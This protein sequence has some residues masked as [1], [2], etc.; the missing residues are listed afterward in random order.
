MLG[1][2]ESLN[3]LLDHFNSHYPNCS[4]AYEPL[5]IKH[6]TRYLL[7]WSFTHQIPK[8]TS[9]H[10][11]RFTAKTKRQQ[12]IPVNENDFDFESYIENLQLKYG[13]SENMSSS[14][15]LLLKYNKWSRKARR[16]S[17]PISL[18]VPMEVSVEFDSKVG[19]IFSVD[20]GADWETFL[21]FINH[22]RKEPKE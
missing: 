21:G 8:D 14:N 7:F 4:F 22:L 16:S 11:L 10:R 2:K 5:R 3:Q 19:L 20:E 9:N 15:K 1:M 13:D 17:E 12:C 18:P 6:T